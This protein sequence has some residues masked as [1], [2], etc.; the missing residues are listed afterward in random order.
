V[1]PTAVPPAAATA[2]AISISPAAYVLFSINVQ[3]FSYPAESAAVLDKIITLH[4][5]TAMP[6]DIYLT[7]AIAQIYADDYPELLARLKSS[8]VV[9]I[10]YHT[11]LPRPYASQNDWLGLK[12]MNAADLTDAILRYETHAV[13]PV[14]GQTTD[15][16][17]GYQ[18]VAALI[19]YPPYAAS[20][21]SGNPDISAA[22]QQVF[23]ALGAQMTVTH[24]PSPTLGETRG[25]LLLRPEQVDYRLF[26]HVGEDAG[27]AF[28][29]ALAEAQ[30][31]QRGDTPVFVDAKMH[32]NNFFAAA[33]AWTT[34]YVQGGKRPPWDVSLRASLLTQDER[35]A[36]WSFY[37]E[38]VR[39]AAEQRAR[40]APV[41]LPL[42]L[43][44]TN[45]G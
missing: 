34:V 1:G 25:G 9:A 22:A 43:A 3:D 11:R 35:T 28:E 12:Q 45:G 19:G 20:A 26:E 29:A 40:V 17:G 37:E 6:V 44:M 10:S 7:D 36:V 33:S 16:P 31:K 32:D 39:Y 18:Q 5:E 21:L 41:N 14:T 27:Q 2:T 8:P 24:G 38:T 42:T 4:E 13:D 30:S 15:A 23:A